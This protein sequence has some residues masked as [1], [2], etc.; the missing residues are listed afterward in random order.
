MTFDQ[1]PA[2]TTSSL[3]QEPRKLRDFYALRAGVAAAWVVAAFSIGAREPLIGAALLVAY[4]AWDALANMIDAARNGGAAA[5]RA[6]VVNAVVSAIV[7]AL[8]LAVIADI[9]TGIGVFGTWAILA[10]LLQLAAGV[11]RWKSYG[12]QWVMVLS[13]AQSALA[14]GFIITRSFGSVPLSV[15]SVAG[16]AAVGA[17]YFLISA[18]WLT[19]R[20]T[21]AG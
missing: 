14:G 7:A 17:F 13:G 6:Q 10:G 1:Q 2:S 11:R 5:N 12:A 16:Y 8:M 18:L 19:F 15:A 20:R 4:P 9:N 3:D 21:K